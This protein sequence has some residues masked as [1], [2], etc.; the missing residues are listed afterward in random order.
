VTGD[1]VAAVQIESGRATGVMLQS[2]C[3]LPAA[4]VV[5]A[6]HPKTI[7]ALIPP[8]LV[9]PSYAK[10]VAEMVDTRG[11]FGVNLSVDAVSHPVL[12][13]NVYRLYPEEDGTLSRGLFCQVRCTD[14]QEANLLSMIAPSDMEEWQLWEGTLSGRRGRDYEA[15]KEEKVRP[16][17]A[18]AEKLFGPLRNATVLDMYTPLTIRDWVGSPGGSPYGI[19]RTTDQLM[20]AASLIRTPLKNLFLAGQNRLS[21]GIMGTMLGSFQAARQV[22]GHERFA[23]D[24]AGA[25]R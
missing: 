11:L 25:L 15:A 14:R 1:G 13:S 19:L 17:I 8:E 22:V 21:P 24:V 20:K 12:P 6:I 7:M 9:R 4:A 10:R 2:G 16:L 18:E 3:M 5:A 23:R